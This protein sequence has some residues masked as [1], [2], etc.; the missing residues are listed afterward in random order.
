MIDSVFWMSSNLNGT[1]IDHS[2]WIFFYNKRANC[3][4]KGRT[5]QE[6]NHVATP[7]SGSSYVGVGSTKR[8]DKR[9]ASPRI[10]IVVVV[11]AFNRK[12][13]R[14]SRVLTSTCGK[15]F[16]GS[17][18]GSR[19]ENRNTTNTRR[20]AYYFWPFVYSRLWHFNRISC[21][22]SKHH[23]ARISLFLCSF[24]FLRKKRDYTLI[25]SAEI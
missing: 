11:E 10:E 24:V 8:W 22:T 6:L 9:R 14:A 2:Y 23:S 1:C 16:S 3:F 19:P 21:L 15:N 25:R 20:G 18:G 5:F 12:C 4:V 13:V 7:F 17:T